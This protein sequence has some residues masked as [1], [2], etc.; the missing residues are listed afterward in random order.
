MLNLTV[1]PTPVG[2]S[3]C[4]PGVAN[5]QFFLS[6]AAA[7]AAA[8]RLGER[9]A[10]QGEAVKLVIELRDG[11][12]GGQFLIPPRHVESAAWRSAA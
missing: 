7:E 11:T 10:R 9:L 1:R 6:G 8:R 4:V 2:W 12:L 5:A 3:L